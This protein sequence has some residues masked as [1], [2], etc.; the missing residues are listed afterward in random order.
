MTRQKVAGGKTSSRRLILKPLN[1]VSFISKKY[2]EINEKVVKMEGEK[3]EIIDENKRMKSE[4]FNMSNELKEMKESFNTLE[5]YSR[6]DCVEVRG[7]PF[8]EGTARE[9]TNNIVVKVSEVMGVNVRKEDISVSHIAY[10]YQSLSL[11]KDALV[12]DLVFK[13]LVQ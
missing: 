5:Q 4:I 8:A 11:H 2:D 3:R 7:I 6:R 12:A 1:T 9:D 13:V 10:Q